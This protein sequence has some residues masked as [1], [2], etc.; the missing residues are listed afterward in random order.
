MIVSRWSRR[1]RLPLDGNTATW[2]LLAVVAV[3][4][5]TQ[6]VLALVPN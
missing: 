1:L 3:I 4:A 5:G 6:A 2:A